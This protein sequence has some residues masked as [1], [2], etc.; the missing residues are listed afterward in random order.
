MQR[1]AKQILDEWLVVSSQ[2]GDRKA[3]HRLIERWYPRLLAQARGQVRDHDGA[4]DVVQEALV[5]VAKDIHRLKDPAAFPHWLY[6]IVYRRGCDWICQRQRQRR[7]AQALT[8]ETD[9]TVS[10]NDE[11]VV[12]Q[13]LKSLDNE[14]YQTMRLFYLEGFSLVEIGEIMSVPVGTVKSRLFNARQKLKDIL[15]DQ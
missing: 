6:R 8:L 2:I 3:F 10:D 14:H 4:A 7:E 9:I 5:I 15:T 12:R 1:S 13:G 11:E